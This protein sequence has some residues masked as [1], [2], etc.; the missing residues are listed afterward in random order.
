MSDST[1]ELRELVAACETDPELRRRL[2]EET[3]STLESVGIDVPDDLR[4]TVLENRRDLI[5]IVLPREPVPEHD[6]TDEELRRPTSGDLDHP[7]HAMR[8][9]ILLRAMFDG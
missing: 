4:V 7:A 8:N 6:V 9:L 2:V 1:I 3:I 5:H